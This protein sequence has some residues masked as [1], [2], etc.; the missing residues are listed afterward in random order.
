MSK[1]EETLRR[2]GAYPKIP[3]PAPEEAPTLCSACGKSMDE[4]GP[5]ER[6]DA[7]TV[8]RF[9]LLGGQWHGGC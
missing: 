5:N 8:A 1:R 3:M 7:P 2:L 9:G 6:P 4:P